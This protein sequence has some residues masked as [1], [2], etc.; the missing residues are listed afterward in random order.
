MR[1]IGF[2]GGA[3]APAVPDQ[4]VTE[5]GP[6]VAREDG[7]ELALNLFRLTLAGELQALGKAGDMGI[8]DDAVIE[9]KGVAEHDIGRLA[10]DAVELDESLHGLGDLAMVQVEEGLATPLNVAG[11][12]AEESDAADILF[13]RCERSLG[14]ISGGPIFLEESGGDEVDLF[15]GGLGG[16]DGGDEQF[17]GRVEPE[18]A[19]GIGIGGLEA[20]DNLIQATG[21]GVIGF[22][23]HGMDSSERGR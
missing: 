23:R 8:D 3:T 9:L 1:A 6:E 11:F 16:E 21:P 12:G 10:A 14:V 19:M 2:S 13:E 18:F 17:E 20:L 5:Q 4:P 7:H 15:V 22:S